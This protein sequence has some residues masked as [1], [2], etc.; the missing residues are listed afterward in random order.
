MCRYLYINGDNIIMQQAMIQMGSIVA[1]AVVVCLL[2]RSYMKEKK[3]WKQFV[4]YIAAPVVVEAV[5]ALVLGQWVGTLI[6]G[7]THE[8]EGNIIEKLQYIAGH[9]GIHFIGTVLVSAILLPLFCHF[10]YDRKEG[11]AILN[12]LAFF[13]TIQHFFNRLGCFMEGCCYGIPMT[14]ILSLRFPDEIV[15][16]SV[17]P[18]QIFEMLCMLCLC[19]IQIVLYRKRKNIFI[20]TM[21]GFG[22]SIFVS[23]FLMNKMGVVMYFGL[24]AIQFAAILLI[25]IAFLLFIIKR[26]APTLD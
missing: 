15:S 5:I 12:I 1:I 21:A 11:D 6:R 19:I 26:K 4:R 3:T 18:S 10:M 25:L 9:A 17:F 20:L 14:G 16:Y 8:V 2:Y 24:D 7:F 22:I 23:E 13:F